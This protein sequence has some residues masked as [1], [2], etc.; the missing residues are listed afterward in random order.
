MN[1]HSGNGLVI[2]K[3]GEN[4]REILDEVYETMQRLS[5]HTHHLEKLEIL[6]EIRDK[7]VDSATGR[8]HLD[9]ETAQLIFKILGAVIVGQLL[10][11]MCLLT[12]QKFGILDLFQK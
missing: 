2:C 7:L 8:R 4:H 6:E 1:E 12:G 5:E 10:I 3:L 9:T 11:V